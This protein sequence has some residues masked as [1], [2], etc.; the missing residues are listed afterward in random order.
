MVMVHAHIAQFS[1]LFKIYFVI[2]VA[3]HKS[4]L[5]QF[6]LI[7]SGVLNVV[8]VWIFW[9][10]QRQPEPVVKSDRG[11]QLKLHDSHIWH[12]FAACGSKMVISAEGRYGKV[13][14]SPVHTCV[15]KSY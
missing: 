6:V 10:R 12:S 14:V 15:V 3:D 13:Y 2:L 9:Q 5:C 4:M 7:N 11:V 8:C 1:L